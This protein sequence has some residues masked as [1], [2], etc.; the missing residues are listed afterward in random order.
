MVRLAVQRR[1]V[2]VTKRSQAHT[3]SKVGRTYLNAMRY[4]Y[5][6]V[7]IIELLRTTNIHS[8]CV[9]GAGQPWIESVFAFLTFDRP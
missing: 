4:Q 5:L 7:A 6:Q 8:L 1:T 9:A 3:T 2:M